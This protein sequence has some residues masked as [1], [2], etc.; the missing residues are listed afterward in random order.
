MVWQ[1]RLQLLFCVDLEQASFN[2]ACC[3]GSE[4]RNL[5]S[6]QLGHTVASVGMRR[7]GSTFSL[8]VDS[9][10]LI[11]GFSRDSKFRVLLGS[12]DD[13][14]DTLA[15]AHEVPLKPAAHCW[16]KPKR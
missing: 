3:D 5:I 1:A 16:P 8:Q 15:V 11:D 6:A 4:Q 14:V 10:R 12:T 2:L 7:A 13:I 9:M